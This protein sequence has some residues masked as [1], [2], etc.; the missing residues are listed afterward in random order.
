[1]SRL[2]IADAGLNPETECGVARWPRVNTKQSVNNG[3][4]VGTRRLPQQNKNLM[5][6]AI[7]GK[8]NICSAG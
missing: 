1:M 4:V 6:R 5:L 8:R 7:V 2:W 3:W